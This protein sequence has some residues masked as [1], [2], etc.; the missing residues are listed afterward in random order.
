MKR[1]FT[2]EEILEILRQQARGERVYDLLKQ[3]KI[4]EQ[5]FYR[6]KSR[7][8]G[9]KIGHARRLKQL[10][11]ENS[12]LKRQVKELTANSEV[13]EWVVEKSLA[14]P[15]R[16]KEFAQKLQEKFGFSERRACRLVGLNRAT[17]R[18]QPMEHHG[19]TLGQEKYKK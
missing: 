2:V 3:H 16:K 5:T 18:Y 4:T 15:A 9:M 8:G 13:L 7:Y 12:R 1:R 11:E 6:W 19:E 17:K 10:E 14:A